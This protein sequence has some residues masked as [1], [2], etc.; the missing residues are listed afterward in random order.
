MTLRACYTLTRY[1]ARPMT[2]E[3]S[4]VPCAERIVSD[5][6]MLGGKPVVKD[7]RIPVAVVLARLEATPD[8]GELLAD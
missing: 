6:R 8:V 4:G 2:T 3:Q 5:P 7:T 1:A